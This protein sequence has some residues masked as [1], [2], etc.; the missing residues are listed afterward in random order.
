M[1]QESH[2]PHF[3]KVPLS[4]DSTKL[5]AMPLTHRPLGARQIHATAEEIKKV[6]QCDRRLDKIKKSVHYFRGT[7]GRLNC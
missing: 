5:E 3:L 7:K 1:I 2:R 4:P 6:T